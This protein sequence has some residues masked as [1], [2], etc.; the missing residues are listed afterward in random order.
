MISASEFD[1]TV[2]RDRFVL[3]PTPQGG[4]LLL[5]DERTVEER[6]HEERPKAVAPKVPATNPPA[7]GAEEEESDGEEYVMDR[8]VAK[9]QN[10]IGFGQAG[11]GSAPM[12]AHGN[13]QK[14]C[15]STRNTG[16][17]GLRFLERGYVYFT[18]V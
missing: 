7:R 14:A 13:G 8:L 10:S 12:T 3:A 18:N 11:F 17:E 1:D 9:S 15:P 4:L 6:Q 5:N 16:S 2:S